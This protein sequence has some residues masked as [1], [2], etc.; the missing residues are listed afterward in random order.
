[1]KRS[2]LILIAILI[3]S[4]FRLFTSLN[5]SLS[6]FNF[7]PLMALAFCAGSL[8][9][10]SRIHQG[11]A[12]GILIVTDLT[13]NAIHGSSG[14][15]TFMFLTLLCYGLVL[16][17]GKKLENRSFGFQIGGLITSSL[18]FYFAT[19]T[20]TWFGSPHYSQS[21]SGWIQAWTLGI[22]GFP[23]TYLFLRNSL[24]SDITFFLIL[25]AFC[26]RFSMG[27][28]TEAHR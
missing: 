25:K 16:F 22:E 12:L 8:G 5:P 9:L 3:A 17:L 14:W 15:H 1:M 26:F 13:L 6:L 11:F 21:L 2:T 18:L 19:N 4:L 23:P 28:L 20:L 24:L 7:S 27:T 10:S